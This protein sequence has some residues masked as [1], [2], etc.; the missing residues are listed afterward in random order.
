MSIAVS[1]CIIYLKL[2]SSI[3]HLSF[4]T[5]QVKPIILTTLWYS[6]IPFINDSFWCFVSHIFHHKFEFKI[7]KI[8]QCQNKCFYKTMLNGWICLNW[9][10]YS[11]HCHKGIKQYCYFYGK[12]LFFKH[13]FSIFIYKHQTQAGRRYNTKIIEA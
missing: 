6:V 5:P 12:G 4:V 13:K 8:K 10:N 7:K 3:D 1:T 11:H 2:R 9:R